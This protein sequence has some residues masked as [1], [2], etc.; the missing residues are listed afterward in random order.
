MRRSLIVGFGRAGRG[1]H[2]HC[3]RKAIQLETGSAL[4]DPSIGII[5]PQLAEIGIADPN[6]E[7][8]KDW[9]EA[10]SRFQPDLTVVHI[11]TP[12]ELHA[13]ALRQA[14]E[15]GYHTII[16]EKPLASSLIELEE[17]QQLQSAYRLD[18]LVVA[19]WLS[20]SLT[21]RIQQLLQTGELGPLRGI[22][23][24][25][26][27]PRLS[28]TLAN[29][30]HGN[31]FDVEIPHIAALALAI[32][33]MTAEVVA[34]DV[35]DMRI[36][37]VQIPKMGS[38]HITLQHTDGVV[39]R[40]SSNLASPVRERAIELEFER[41]TVCGYYPSG[42]DDSYSWL[43][44]YTKEGQLISEEIVFDDPLTAV[45]EDFYSYFNGHGP[46]PV[47]DLSFNA[48]V[49]R[50]ICQAKSLCGLM[51]HNESSTITVAAQ[52]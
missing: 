21:K 4:F 16:M 34:A 29:S 36:G 6:L 45:F 25:Q 24:Y 33:G 41:H 18:V 12:P 2:Y 1:L 8:F 49:V 22:T 42:Q 43:R 50:T 38:A 47:S 10:K 26:N 40:L 32:G 3:L 48:H 44:M 20:S 52:R 5:D 31:A 46:K 19:N 23:A 7:L 39:T 30:S 11:C 35:A 28:R 37:Q 51:S 15:H 17:I 9:D 14:A 27:K 13:A